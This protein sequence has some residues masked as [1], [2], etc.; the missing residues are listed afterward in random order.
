MADEIRDAFNLVYA[1]GPISGPSQPKKSEIRPIGGLIQDAVDAL[2]TRVVTVEGTIAPIPAEIINL[3]T[4]VTAAEATILTGVKPLS[5]SVRLA[6]TGNIT[7]SGEQ[8]IDG[9]LTSASDVSV[10]KQADP[11]QNGVYTSG[12]GAWTRRTDLDTGAELL[13]SRFMVREGTTYGGY[14]LANT[15]TTAPLVGTDNITFT[16]YQKA[17]PSVTAEV[18]TARAGA[19]SVGARLDAA[20]DQKKQMAGLGYLQELFGDNNNMVATNIT[21]GATPAY[22]AT[23]LTTGL[24]IAQTT[25]GNRIVLYSTRNKIGGRHTRFRCRQTITSF[26]SSCRVGF[27]LFDGT[28]RSTFTL[29]NAGI[30]SRVGTGAATI[31]TSGPT[32]ANGDVIE[33]RVDVYD[34]GTIYVQLFKNSEA[35]YSFGATGVPVGDVLSLAQSSGT[36]TSTVIHLLPKE[37]SFDSLID[38]FGRSRQDER[39]GASEMGDLAAARLLLQTMRRNTPVGWTP[40]ISSARKFYFSGAVYFGNVNLTLAQVLPVYDPDV[41][42]LYVDIATGSDINIGSAASPLKSKTAALA[43]C[44]AGSKAIVYVKGG[45]YDFDNCWKSAVPASST[46]AVVSWDGVP[47]ISSMH[48]AGLVWALDSGTTYVAT[49]AGR[50]VNVWD[51]KTANLTA[52]GDYGRLPI[53]STLANCRST[54]ASYFVSGTSIYVNTIDGRAPD[55]DI[56]VYKKHATT[57]ANDTNGNYQTRNGT[58]YLEGIYFEGGVSPFFN[59]ID[60]PAYKMNVYARDCT[61]KYGG[62]DNFDINGDTYCVLQNCIAA[63]SAQDGFNYHAIFGSAAP[64][65]IE[66]SCIG[67]YNGTDTAGTNNGSTIHEGGCIIRVNGLYH[68]NQN[69]NVH[70]IGGSFSWNMGCT[71]RDSTSGINSSNFVAGL[72]G[73]NPGTQTWL[74]GCTSSG[75]LFQLEAG[76]L[77]TIR[78]FNLTASGANRT[79]TNYAGTITTYVPA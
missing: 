79:G 12:A 28:N 21:D 3:T 63:W 31:S 35:P 65:V 17:D 43:R 78:T 15:N 54:P 72:V 9:T 2:D 13:G 73:E 7:L 64:Q 74:D 34:D 52:D 70:D 29:S 1:D 58:I 60:D 36:G 11:K 66:I 23:A 40:T 68:H 42:K 24:Q 6:T 47:V 39:I 53:A 55:A 37:S 56:R 32:F 4:R 76:D 51:A 20:A 25:G 59:R 77:S 44:L 16:E 62:T 14:I 38:D 49:F 57:T 19:A 61:F 45:L 30:I 41:I 10:W 22:V 50:V 71:A 46:I 48:D 5:A 18:T 8:T 27:S 67:R 75:S 33:W 26:P 69:R